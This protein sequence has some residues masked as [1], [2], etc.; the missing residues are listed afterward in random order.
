MAFDA[1]SLYPSAM[2]QAESFPDLTSAY[3]IGSD[4]DFEAEHFIIKC[5]VF[6]PEHL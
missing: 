6:L 5:D 2:L 3:L 4:F 1:T